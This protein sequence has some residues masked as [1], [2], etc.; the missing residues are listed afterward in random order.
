MLFHLINRPFNHK[1]CRNHV[2]ITT[3]KFVFIIHKGKAILINI[4]LKEY[5]AEKVS[6]FGEYLKKMM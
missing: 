3:T 6:A 4:R 1:P 5:I 2:S